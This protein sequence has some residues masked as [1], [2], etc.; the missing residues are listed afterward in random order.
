VTSDVEPERVGHPTGDDA[1]EGAVAE[2]TR[3]ILWHLGQ[4][5][6]VV[7]IHHAG[8]HPGASTP[9]ARGVDSGPLERFPGDLQQQALLGVH[10]YRLARADAEEV[11]VELRRPVQEGTLAGVGLARF[12]RFRVVQRVGVPAAVGGE[13]RDSVDT[14]GDQAP[15]VLG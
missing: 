4:P 13:L 7:V 14:V 6:A 15:Q 2:V 10:R 9:D 3:N 5:A 1:A 12:A 11:R 8:E